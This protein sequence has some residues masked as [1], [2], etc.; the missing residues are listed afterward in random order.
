MLMIR[1]KRMFCVINNADYCALSRSHDEPSLGMF[2]QK[3]IYIQT[4]HVSDSFANSIHE[5][6]DDE[7]RH[8]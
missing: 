7:R 1:S 8:A 3:T 2:L 4:L 5:L 6:S